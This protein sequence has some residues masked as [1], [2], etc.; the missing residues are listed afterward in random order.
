MPQPTSG[1]TTNRNKPRHLSLAFFPIPEHEQKASRSISMP[2]LNDLHPLL[3]PH[4][5]PQSWHSRPNSLVRRI[6]LPLHNSTHDTGDVFSCPRQSGCRDLHGSHIRGPRHSQKARGKGEDEDGT[7]EEHPGGEMPP[8]HP[9]D[10]C[11]TA[12]VK[13][14]STPSP[15]PP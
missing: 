13:R 2:T 11:L 8:Y 14:G 7:A 4:H 5:L 9:F 1:Y 3:C 12:Q 6:Y 15:P 10:L